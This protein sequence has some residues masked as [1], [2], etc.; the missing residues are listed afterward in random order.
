MTTPQT[1]LMNNVK[2]LMV[3]SFAAGYGASGAVS[4]FN[5]ISAQP[6]VAHLLRTDGVE[7]MGTAAVIYVVASLLLRRTDSSP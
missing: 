1:R 2:S 3:K 7:T 4:I 6:Q 5:S